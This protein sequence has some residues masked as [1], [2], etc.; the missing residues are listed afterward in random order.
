MQVGRSAPSFSHSSVS[1]RAAR[2]GF[3]ERLISGVLVV[4]SH[5]GD[6]NSLQCFPLVRRARWSGAPHRRVGYRVHHTTAMCFFPMYS[7]T[8]TL[9]GPFHFLSESPN[10]LWSLE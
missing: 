7:F 10:L 2:T 9:T 3:G 6:L 4:F 8:S 5:A 1:R